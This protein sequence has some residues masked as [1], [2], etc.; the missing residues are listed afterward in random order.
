MMFS[1]VGFECILWDINKC[2]YTFN[3]RSIVCHEDNVMCYKQ[4]NGGSYRFVYYIDN[5]PVSGLQ[6]MV[7]NGR[8]EAANVFTVKEHRR[9]GYSK[10]VF[11]EALKHFRHISFSKN[12]NREGQIYV[13][14]CEHITK[15]SKRLTVNN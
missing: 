5:T 15:L 10:I 8:A 4:R 11:Q 13:E 1:S 7:N 3:E 6:I 9:K 12:R 14:S 2:P